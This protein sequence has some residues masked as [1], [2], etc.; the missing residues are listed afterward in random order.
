MGTKNLAKEV[1]KVLAGG[2]AILAP[3]RTYVVEIDDKAVSQASKSEASAVSH[4]R[5]YLEL[6]VCRLKVRRSASSR[7][8]RLRRGLGTVAIHEGHHQVSETWS[9]SKLS[10]EG[11]VIH[12]RYK[13]RDENYVPKIAGFHF[14]NSHFCN[15]ANHQTYRL[16]N[17]SQMSDGKPAAR[18]GQY[19]K[20]IESIMKPCTFSECDEITLLCFLDQFDSSCDSNRVS[21]GMPLWILSN[22]KKER[23]RAIFNNLLVPIGVSRVSYARPKKGD[24]KIKTHVVAVTH[25]LKPYATKVNIAKATSETGEL[26]K[27]S[28]ESAVQFADAVWLKAARY[29]NAYPGEC[30]KEVFIDSLS[31]TIRSGAQ[32]C[33]GS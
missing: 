5:P 2:P 4:P 9:L 1:V 11:D 23:P 13:V 21:E 20:R 15:M 26:V 33:F 7:V 24:D 6:T 17:K 29:S 16:V 31:P 14:R 27:L 8:G 22:F 12:R 32:M 25:L 10:K 19:V 18:M 3:T 28:Y 30:I